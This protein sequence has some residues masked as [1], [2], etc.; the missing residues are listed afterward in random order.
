M[1]EIWCEKRK[2]YGDLSMAEAIAGFLHLAFTVDLKY[3][4]V[5]IMGSMGEIFELIS[6]KRLDL[7]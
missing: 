5:S 4:S 1:F 2:L 7:Q 6:L 3:P